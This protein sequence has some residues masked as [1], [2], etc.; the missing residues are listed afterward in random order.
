MSINYLRHSLWDMDSGT[1][2]ENP[3]TRFQRHSGSGEQ[4]PR[5]QDLN[6]VENSKHMVKSAPREPPV[7]Q[8]HS[9]TQNDRSVLEALSLDSFHETMPGP[10]ND[11]YVHTGNPNPKL[12]TVFLAIAI[13]LCML[14]GLAYV[15]KNFFRLKKGSVVLPPGLTDIAAKPLAD[16]GKGAGGRGGLLGH[17]N[18]T[19]L[20]TDAMGVRAHV[21][22]LYEVK[23]NGTP[24][25]ELQMTFEERQTQGRDA[26]DL[27]HR[28]MA[29]DMAL[30]SETNSLH[31]QERSLLDDRMETQSSGSSSSMLEHEEGPMLGLSGSG[32][33]EEDELQQETQQNRTLH[34]D[35]L[36]A[37][38]KI[39]QQ[40]Q[41]Q[42]QHAVP[43]HMPPPKMEIKPV[44]NGY[45]QVQVSEWRAFV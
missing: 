41:Q 33:Q 22:E 30:H 36:E 18:G 31:E 44:G 28:A 12:W 42:I 15:S 37:M 1:S 25:G 21:D 9:C 16:G 26:S 6:A 43:V 13:V 11:V 23:G 40:Q 7:K 24:N 39:K 20:G 32:C 3:T 8:L 19:I 27:G 5:A 17:G 34:Q 35:V 45:V 4:L 14:A 10:W 2:T 38:T 29:I